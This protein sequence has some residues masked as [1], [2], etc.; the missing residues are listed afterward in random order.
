MTHIAQQ[1]RRWL[2]KGG[3]H[4]NKTPL[5]PQEAPASRK[6]KNRESKVV[7]QAI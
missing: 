3:G 2:Q 1:A 5:R 6:V 4:R 7:G